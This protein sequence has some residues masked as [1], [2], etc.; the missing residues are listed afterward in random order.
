MKRYFSYLTF[1]F[2]ISFTF[3]IN[4]KAETCDR[5]D[6]ARLKE[7]ANRVTYD[8]EYM[9]GKDGYGTQDYIVK[10]NNLGKDFY[11]LYEDFIYRDNDNIVVRS[12]SYSFDI[13]ST[14]CDSGVR[15]VN[16]KLKKFNEFSTNAL[17]VEINNSIPECDPW[18]QGNI[19]EITFEKIIDD[20]H[21]SN[22]DSNSDFFNNISNIFL[23]YWFFIVPSIIGIIFIIASIR[24]R[25][26]R[27]D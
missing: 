23:S 14:S 27:L 5:E 26:N 9:G 17:C 7:L 1:I 12:G 10:F 11:V 8:H 25:R 22:S 16:V 19:D 21:K 18:Y 20:Y 24:I 6:M 2:I 3:N 13:Y 15:S 4:V